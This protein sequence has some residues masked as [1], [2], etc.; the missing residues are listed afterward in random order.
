M[1]TSSVKGRWVFLCLSY[2]MD[3]PQVGNWK[4]FFTA[5]KTAEWD[6]WIHD[7]TNGIAMPKDTT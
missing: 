7:N 3:S 2:V 1:T 6:K 4:N 5:E